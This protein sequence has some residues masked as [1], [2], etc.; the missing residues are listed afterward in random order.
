M[1]V[2]CYIIYK[3]IKEKMVMADFIIK[4]PMLPSDY[5]N[6]DGLIDIAKD[7]CQKHNY[8]Y[9]MFTLTFGTSYQIMVIE[10]TKNDSIMMDIYLYLSSK[11]YD[12]FSIAKEVDFCWTG[13][14]KTLWVN[15]ALV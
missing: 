12:D 2:F 13:L 10:C 14:G 3:N 15:G 6:K 5:Y 1:G 4:N 11:G 9:K 7:Y 8:N